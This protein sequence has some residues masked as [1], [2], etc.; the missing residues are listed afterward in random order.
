MSS[1]H[2]MSRDSFMPTSHFKSTSAFQTQSERTLHNKAQ[3]R[4]QEP[5]AK[6]KTIYNDWADR[7]H[8]AADEAGSEGLMVLE[9]NLLDLRD[10]IMESAKLLG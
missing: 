9:G 5:A 6:M 2:P 8:E 4:P 1:H 10:E 7:I 3:E